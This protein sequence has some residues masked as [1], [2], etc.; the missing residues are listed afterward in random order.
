MNSFMLK[1]LFFLFNFYFVLPII[2]F[3]FIKEIQGKENVPQKENF[4]IA[5]NHLNTLDHWILAAVLKEKFFLFRFLGKKKGNFLTRN[6]RA[7]LYFLSDTVSFDEDE[8]R[9]KVLNKLEKLLKTGKIVIIYPEED[10]NKERFLK[11]G[12]TGIAELVLKS[13]F[14]VLPIGFS[15]DKK[16]LVKIGR[17]MNFNEEQKKF[18]NLNNENLKFRLLQKVVDKIMKEISY[19]SGKPYPY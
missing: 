6:L 8:N 3:L 2:K 5:A 15:E 14:P 12:K 4:I 18:I 16:R 10:V 13:G 7:V 19:L 1:Y 11:R 9:E 17:L